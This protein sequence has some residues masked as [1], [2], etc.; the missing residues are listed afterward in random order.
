MGDELPARITKLDRDKYMSWSMELEHIM[1]LRGCWS[2]VV[3]LTAGSDGDVPRADA[4][5]VANV[6]PVLVS[7]AGAHAEEQARSLIVLNVKQRH[8]TT[9]RRHSTA[10]GARQA[11]EQQFRYRGPA[12][13]DNLRRAMAAMKQERNEPIMDYFNRAGDIAWELEALGGGMAEPQLVS[14][15]LAGT[16]PKHEVTVKLLLRV[17]DLDL[18]VAMEELCS[19]EGCVGMK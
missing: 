5:D 3:P 1:R 7:Q 19:D 13:L 10:R 16:P 17:K 9:L 12:R 8:L 6:A 15:L 2:A 14:A 4:A 11:L 18:D